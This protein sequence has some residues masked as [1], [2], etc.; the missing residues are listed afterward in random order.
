M[1]GTVFPK[2]AAFYS[3]EAPFTWS[4]LVDSLSCSKWITW[5]GST[6]MLG[7]YNNWNTALGQGHQMWLDGEDHQR[8]LDA[9]YNIIHC[10][11]IEKSY[12]WGKRKHQLLRTYELCQGLCTIDTYQP[13]NHTGINPQYSTEILHW[14]EQWLDRTKYSLTGFILPCGRGK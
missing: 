5:Y 10:M 13:W 7:L 9:K 1:I 6:A 12:W 8:C 11:L 4:T 3:P 2:L 14:C